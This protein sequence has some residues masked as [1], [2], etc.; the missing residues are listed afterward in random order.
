[1]HLQKQKFKIESNI[2][3]A[4]K[5]H[6]HIFLVEMLTSGSYTSFELFKKNKNN[7]Y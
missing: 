5:T 2:K 7:L 6:A 4:A 3:N 1:M